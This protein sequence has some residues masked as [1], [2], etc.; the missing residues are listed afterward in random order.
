MIGEAGKG[1]APQ[2]Q[3]GERLGRPGPTFKAD[4]AIDPVEGTSYLARGQTNALAVLA[5]APR[6][7]MMNPAPAFYMEK[8]VAP[9]PARGKIDP[10]WSTGRKLRVLAEALNKDISQLTIYRAREAAPPR[11]DRGHHQGRRPRSA[12]SGRRRCRRS[13]RRHSGVGHRRFDGNWRHA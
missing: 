6:G 7:A 2:P 4:I 10:H 8:F 5:V 13:A 12:L 11:A 3:R 9:A 1:E